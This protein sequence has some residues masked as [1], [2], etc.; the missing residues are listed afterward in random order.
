MIDKLNSQSRG[1]I[2]LENSPDPDGTV[3]DFCR[4]ATD[5][6]KSVNDTTG[7]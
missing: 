3:P 6:K 7:F 2:E 4:H 5:M 1:I